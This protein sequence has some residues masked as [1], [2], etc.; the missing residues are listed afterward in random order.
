MIQQNYSKNYRSRHNSYFGPNN[1]IS[2]RLLRNSN[3]FK[4]NPNFLGND[5]FLVP[6]LSVR[7]CVA[8]ND[9]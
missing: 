5:F 4:D 2:H 1:S 8:N 7:N 3:K 6:L 9:I